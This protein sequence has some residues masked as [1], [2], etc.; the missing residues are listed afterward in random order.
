MSG[1]LAEVDR[2]G[3]F[4]A[5]VAPVLRQVRLAHVVVEELRC[6]HLHNLQ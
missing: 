2:P 6:T 5:V 3:G 1:K 4:A